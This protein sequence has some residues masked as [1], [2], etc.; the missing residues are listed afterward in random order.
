MT[1]S[2]K[3]LEDLKRRLSIQKPWLTDDELIASA[4]KAF[5]QRPWRPWLI[6]FSGQQERCGWD[7]TELLLKAS[8]PILVLLI[9]TLFAVLTS[10]RAERLSREQREY[11]VLQVFIREMQ[12]LLLEKNLKRAAKDSEARGVAR[13]L[14]IATLNQIKSSKLKTIAIRFLLDSGLNYRPGNLISLSGADLSTIDLSQADIRGVILRKADLSYANLLGARIDG[15]DFTGANL[16][17]ANLWGATNL[18]SAILD[19]VNL[20]GANLRLADLRRIR[21]YL[22][23]SYADLRWA[24]LQNMHLEGSNFQGANLEGADLSGIWVVMNDLSGTSFRKADL[25]NAHLLSVDLSKSDLTEAN[26]YNI[27]WDEH[28]KWPSPSMMRSAKNVPEK[29]RKQLIL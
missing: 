17:G 24:N 4:R 23:V 3:H 16:K 18:H 9:S 15:A 11:D 21:T 20:S 12:P 5:S 14:T 13:G 7:W 26:L 27:T 1:K 10:Q 25:S 6:H 29:L 28:T 2:D 19:E 8:L 22:N